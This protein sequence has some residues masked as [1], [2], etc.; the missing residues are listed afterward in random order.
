M[1]STKVKRIFH[2]NKILN[3]DRLNIATA[4]PF[5]DGMNVWYALFIGPYDSVYKG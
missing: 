1:S 3:Q 5:E 4:Y 2:E